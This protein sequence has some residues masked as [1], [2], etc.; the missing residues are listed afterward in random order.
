MTMTRKLTGKKSGAVMLASRSKL[1]RA[2]EGQVET[3]N[4]P[5]SL[6]ICGRRAS[7]ERYAS[8]S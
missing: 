3:V 8:C 4:A 2:S 5:S 1:I 7:A 6:V